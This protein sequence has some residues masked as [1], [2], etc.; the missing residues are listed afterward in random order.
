MN[1]F[2]FLLIFLSI[3]FSYC[4]SRFIH[5]K[6]KVD[7]VALENVLVF[8]ESTSKFG[9]TDE[10]G[11]YGINTE[12]VKDS[13]FIDIPGYQSRKT[14]FE[15]LNKSI[16][17]KR[18]INHLD[19]VIINAPDVKNL[20]K[21]TPKI[22]NKYTTSFISSGGAMLCSVD[23]KKK[24]KNDSLVGF[25]FKIRTRK[26]DVHARPLLVKLN[27]KTNEWEFLLQTPKTLAL[28]ENNNSLR[29]DLSD[30]KI[31]F[32]EQFDYLIGF[33]LID[34][35]NTEDKVLVYGGES[36]NANLYLKATPKSSWNRIQ[37]LNYS[38]D[39]TLYVKKTD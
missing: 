32:S 29:F 30:F 2:L 20:E 11:K 15:K 23:L 16:Y 5:V 39:Y 22:K 13:I 18:K 17:L 9:Y 3:N 12:N 27:P 26:N 35:N 8:N 34:R 7:S 4:Q 1:L 14:T 25:K 37:N 10:K 38:L 33:E 19:E 31:K 24:F 21:F 28:K 36:K 6:S